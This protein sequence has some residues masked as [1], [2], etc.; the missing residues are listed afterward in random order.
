MNRHRTQLL[1]PAMLALALALAGCG[2]LGTPTVTL[3]A[4]NRQVRT[5]ADM[6]VLQDTSKGGAGRLTL[7]QVAGEPTVELSLTRW[8]GIYPTD[9]PPQWRWRDREVRLATSAEVLL[10]QPDVAWAGDDSDPNVLVETVTVKLDARRLALA[11]TPGAAV[12]VCDRSAPTRT[13]SWLHPA[14]CT[15]YTL[16]GDQRAQIRA[17]V[18]PPLP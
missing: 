12:Q 16:T 6:K 14:G 4:D 10:R 13:P 5:L 7:T 8:L 18:N 1:T 17:W 15:P 11:M 3:D 9:G 2:T